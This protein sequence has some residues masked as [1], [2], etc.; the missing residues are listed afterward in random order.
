MSFSINGAGI[1]KFP[2]VKKGKKVF[3]SQIHKNLLKLDQRHKCHKKAMN[4]LEEKKN[5]CYHVF[6]TLQ[7]EH[8]K[9]D[10]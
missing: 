3:T 4:F 2:Y 7:T 6:Y 1:F 5:T 9:S 8:K 10:I